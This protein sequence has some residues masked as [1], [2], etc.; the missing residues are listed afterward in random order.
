MNQATWAESVF[1]MYT[2]LVDESS[3]GID[4]RALL[5]SLAERGIQTRPLWQ[6]GHRSPAHATSVSADYPVADRIGRDALSLP[7]SVGLER[8]EQTRVVDALQEIASL[9]MPD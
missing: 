7:C 1:W 8:S 2:V 5:E 4:S 3:F 6:P 9:N